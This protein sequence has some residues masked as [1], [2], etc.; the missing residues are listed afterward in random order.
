MRLEAKKAKSTTKK[1]AGGR[2]AQAQRVFPAVADHVESQ[3][4]G[5]QH[6]G[7]DRDAVGRRQV[8]GR[9]EHHHR[10]HDGDE[11]APVDEGH[12]DLAG[13]AHAGVLDVEARQIAHL[14]GLLGHAEGAGDQGLRGDHRGHGGQAHQRQQRPFGRHQVE[15][16]FHGGGVADQQGALAEVIEHQRGHD[17]REPGQAYRLLAEVAE[18]GV[19]RLGAGHAQH[20]GAQDD[21]GGARVV[22][23]EHQGV[24]RAQRHQDVGVGGDLR[25]AQQRQH[26]KPDQRDRPEKFAD[27]GR[28][29]FLHREQGEQNDQGDG[30]HALLEGRRDDFQAFDRRQHRNRR[31]DDAVAV[32]Q[33]GAEDADDQQ[34]LAQLGL[35]FHRGGGQRQHGDQAAF[36]VVVGA[37]HQRHVLD[38]NDD[39]QRPE[40]DGQDAV[41]VVGGERNVPGTENFLDG[42]QD[43]GSD[44]AVDDTDGAQGERR[45]G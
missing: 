42:I 9:A 32:K 40:E 14:D 11:Q 20:H 23:H 22:P 13:V 33:G 31:R 17:H 7:A 43:A 18:V 24:V 35:V 36:A 8:A 12:V 39:G 30:D 29:V 28:A 1:D 44:V 16:V 19:Q 2:D 41:D 27:A 34:G 45:E 6:V 37:Q 3:D 25:N 5:D 26:A 38:G 4:G 15:R 21:E 10:E